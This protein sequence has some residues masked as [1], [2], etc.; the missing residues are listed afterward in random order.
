LE[1][2]DKDNDLKSFGKGIVEGVATSVERTAMIASNPTA[3]VGAMAGMT[4]T[5]GEGRASMKESMDECKENL[6]K[7]AGKTAFH[8]AEN[9]FTGGAMGLR[10]LTKMGYGA[11]GNQVLR[12]AGSGTAKGAAATKN[13]VGMKAI[14]A[15]PKKEI[16]TYKKAKTATK[17]TSGRLAKNPKET[18]GNGGGTSNLDAFISANAPAP[19]SSK[20]VKRPATLAEDWLADKQVKKVT[21]KE[22]KNRKAIPIPRKAQLVAKHTRGRK[23][24]YIKAS[25]GKLGGDRSLRSPVK[26]VKVKKDVKKEMKVEKPKVEKE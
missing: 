12:T 6:A 4:E 5:P 9:T 23:S 21:K 10:K 18:A 25:V 22:T 19:G 2:G 17:S 13:A 3:M 15:T 1:R 16:S 8:V 20:P 26:N 14:A 11:A 24:K 7:C